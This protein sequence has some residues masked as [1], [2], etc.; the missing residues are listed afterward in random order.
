MTIAAAFLDA[1]ETGAPLVLPA[2]TQM[3]Q[4]N[5]NFEAI[6]FGVVFDEG[7][8]RDFA[9]RHGIEILGEPAEVY[10]GN[11]VD[12]FWRMYREIET[13]LFD[14]GNEV[15]DAFVVDLFNSLQPRVKELPAVE[16]IKQGAFGAAVETVAVQ[17][18][19]ERDWE[20]HCRENMPN[21]TGPEEE[22]FVPFAR[23]MEKIKFSLPETKRIFA[24]CDEAALPVAPAALK[25]ACWSHYR[26]YLVF[27]SDFLPRAEMARLKPVNL[28]LLDFE[29][30]LAA[31]V[32][33]G[34]SRSTFSNL[35]GI[36]TYCASGKVPE[37]HYIYNR[38]GP[39]LW[40]RTDGGRH[41]DAVAATAG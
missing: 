6:P 35:A 17:F 37:R 7:K 39:G 29:M 38:R 8:I 30:A 14:D 2:I 9:G 40:R 13:G 31:E 27:K 26:I 28:S 1:L 3:D 32:F 4:V 22:L 18:R 24:M 25:D 15:R 12:Y 41:A 10:A 5:W 19:I 11:Y 20:A 16:K 21:I 34:T 36:Q 33:V 23:I